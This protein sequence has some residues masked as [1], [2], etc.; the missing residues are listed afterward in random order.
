MCEGFDDLGFKVTVLEATSED[1][2]ALR[3]AEIH[4]IL[5]KSPNINKYKMLTYDPGPESICPGC[6][7]LEEE[8]VDAKTEIKRLQEENKRLRAQGVA[9]NPPA[10]Q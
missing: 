7:W 1:S 10:S 2:K 6:A 4:W 5:K 3:D 9:K 8:L